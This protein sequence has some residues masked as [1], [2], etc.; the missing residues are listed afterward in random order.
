MPILVRRPSESDLARLRAAK[1]SAEYVGHN[2]EALRRFK[3]D[4]VVLHGER[5]VGRGDTPEAAWAD[6]K[7]APKAEC[8]LVRVPRPD[9]A[10]FF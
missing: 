8:I 4:Y 7:N 10:F 9:E 5:V 6:M 2:I 3:R 1:A